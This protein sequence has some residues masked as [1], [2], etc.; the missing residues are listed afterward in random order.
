MLVKRAPSSVKPD[1]AARIQRSR[2]K[3]IRIFLDYIYFKIIF[4]IRLNIAILLISPNKSALAKFLCTVL[5][6]DQANPS[7][8]ELHMN[9]I[10]QIY[11]TICILL[12]TQFANAQSFT[13]Q[14]PNLQHPNITTTQLLAQAKSTKPDRVEFAQKKNVRVVPTSDGKSFFLVWY[15]DSVK[16]NPTKPPVIVTFSG[17][18]SFAYDE[19][20][21]W[22]PLAEKFGFGII[23]VQWWLG[24]GEKINDYYF[25]REIYPDLENLLRKERIQPGN[26][27]AHGFSR[28][29][30][31]I[32][33]LTFLDK[34]TG[35]NFIGATIANAG[36]IQDSFPENRPLFN[37]KPDSLKGTHWILYCGANDP[38]PERD[39]CQ[40][41]AETRDWLVSR[42]STV[43]VFIQDPN[44][45]HGGFH[46]SLWASD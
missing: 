1:L 5:V 2:V 23:A 32:Y 6:I 31:N 13:P 41:M 33:S 26:V 17:H 29:S 7:I 20:F 43:D 45:D 3:G 44:G 11:I 16:N 25:M 4:L 30:A 12:L 14:H 34:M 27:L 40:G 37:S 38:N 15:P 24:Q 22:Q 35:N 21:L 18:G 9:I 8:K 19:F 10:C 28:G 36:K 46:R 39:G 42:G